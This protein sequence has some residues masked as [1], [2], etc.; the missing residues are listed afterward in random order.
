MLLLKLRILVKKY[1]KIGT[2]KV[3]IELFDSDYFERDKKREKE[4]EML[5]SKCDKLIMFFYKLN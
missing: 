2:I 4:K 1:L 5:A 3:I